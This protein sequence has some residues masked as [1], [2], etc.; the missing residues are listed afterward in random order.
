[1]QYEQHSVEY[2]FEFAGHQLNHTEWNTENHH[3]VA[4]A[5]GTLTVSRNTSKLK[6]SVA[7]ETQDVPASY[8]SAYLRALD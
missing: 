6:S 5:L 2:A 8:G 7:A 4:A 1:M 3:F